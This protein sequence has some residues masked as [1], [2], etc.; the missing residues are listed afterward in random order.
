[1]AAP[2]DNSRVAASGSVAATSDGLTLSAQLPNGVAGDFLFACVRFPT[3]TGMNDAFWTALVNNQ[4]PDAADDVTFIGY[5]Q[6]TAANISTDILSWNFA[7]S[8]KWAA[9]YYLIKGAADTGHEV[10]SATTGTG[11]NLDPA[12]FSPAGGANDWLYISHIGLDGETQT[13]TAPSGYANRTDADSGTGGAVASN[14]RIS[15]ASKGTT[16]TSSENPGAWTHAAPNAGVTAYTIAIAPPAT[17]PSAAGGMPM[18]MTL[19]GT[20][21]QRFLGFPFPDTT[22]PL[23]VA[24][25][26]DHLLVRLQA[27]NRSNTF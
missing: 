16:G 24:A 11:A 5:H 18:L 8:T 1:M 26:P 6:L 9:V 3:S 23:V 20:P 19:F 4:S 25:V 2:T 22:P 27:V 12:S 21:V 17:V 10:S 15:V 7:G 13:F 14:C